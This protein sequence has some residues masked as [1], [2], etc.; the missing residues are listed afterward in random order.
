[1]KFKQVIL[2][3]M[4]LGMSAGKTAVQVAHGAVSASEAARVGWG[5]W[6]RRWMDEGQCKIV[7]K[8]GSEEELLRFDKLAGDEDLPKALVFDRG[9]TEVPPGT[10]TCLAIGPAPVEKVDKLTGGLPLL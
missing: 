10:V 4:D 5:E 2:V 6:W 9:L 7:L 1:M 8:V 3:R